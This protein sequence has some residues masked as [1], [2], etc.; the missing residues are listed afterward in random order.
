MKNGAQ[1][2]KR[3]ILVRDR[4]FNHIIHV[5]LNYTDNDFSELA[6]HR[7]W[8]F[9]LNYDKKSAYSMQIGQ[10]GKP[11]QWIIALKWF[12][13]KGGDFG[14]LVHEIH[15]TVVSILALHDVKITSD[16]QEF[17]AIME[18]DLFEKISW[19]IHYNKR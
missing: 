15:H 2:G 10:E 7:G 12:E 5:Y 3:Y 19:K 4:I 17:S 1:I 9:A 14:T 13:W 6:R 8:S 16:T 18:E 11:D